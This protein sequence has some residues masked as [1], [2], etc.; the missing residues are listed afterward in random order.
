MIESVLSENEFGTV[1]EDIRIRGKTTL[2]EAVPE[3]IED[4]VDISGKWIGTFITESLKSREYIVDLKI[5]QMGKIL[6]GLMDVTYKVNDK[7][8]H[9]KEHMKG[10]INNEDVTLYGTTITIVEAGLTTGYNPDYFSLKL[11]EENTLMEGIFESK[12]SKGTV[13]LRKS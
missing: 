3:P 8:T 7:Q 12:N 9:I 11:S 6:E 1:F 13:I 5:A 2:E 10:Q 4:I